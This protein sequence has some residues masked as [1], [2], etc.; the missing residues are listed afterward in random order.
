MSPAI[1]PLLVGDPGK[2]RQVILNLVGNAVKFTRQGGIWVEAEVIE[3][4][5]DRLR[6]RLAVRDTGIGIPA[7]KQ[8][9]IFEAFSQADNSTTRKFGGT[10]WAG[11][12]A[13]PGPTDGRPDRVK[14]EPGGGSSFLLHR[15]FRA[16]IDETRN[17]R[18]CGSWPANGCWWWTIT[19]PTGVLLGDNFSVGMAA[20]M[21]ESGKEALELAAARRSEEAI[22]SWS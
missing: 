8:E 17:R 7:D 10:G 9:A 20:A 6:I 16:G 13:A 14:S 5:R 2:I 11:D 19:P 12:F 3:D 4:R 21:A 22:F 1:P 18:P 15:P